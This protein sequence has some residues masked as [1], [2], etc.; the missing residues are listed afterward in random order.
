MPVLL[1]Q[2]TF[3]VVKRIEAV[4]SVE[5]FVVLAVAAFH[6]AVMPRKAPYEVMYLTTTKNQLRQVLCYWVHVVAPGRQVLEQLGM[7]A[8]VLSRE[9]WTSIVC[10]FLRSEKPL[11]LAIS[12]EM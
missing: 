3:E 12:T 6:F 2:A 7:L 10:R 4:Q 8:K 1:R 9:G 11:V 5:L